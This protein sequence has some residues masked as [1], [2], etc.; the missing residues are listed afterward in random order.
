MIFLA[1]LYYDISV[2]QMGNNEFA[3]YDSF[4]LPNFELKVQL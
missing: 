3:I 1:L 4:W 2:C